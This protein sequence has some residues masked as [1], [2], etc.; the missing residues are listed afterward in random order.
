M[1]NTRDISKAITLRPREIADAYGISVATVTRWCTL[2]LIESTK[3]GGTRG[4]RMGTRLVFRESLDR[5][6]KSGM[7]GAK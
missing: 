6:L 5:Y 2:G 1:K 7:K 4:G 3:L